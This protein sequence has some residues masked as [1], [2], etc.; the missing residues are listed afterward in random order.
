MCAKMSK[1]A[2]LRPISESNSDQ[3]YKQ[4]ED[5]LLKEINALGIGPM[6][7]HGKTT[8]LKVQIQYAPTHIAGL[9]VAVNMCCH[10]C[11]HAKVVIS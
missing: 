4:L 6:G 7:L 10:V 9:P 8:A 2:L 3:R 5:D 1:E 11:R